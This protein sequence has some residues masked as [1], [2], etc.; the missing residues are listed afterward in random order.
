MRTLYTSHPIFLLFVLASIFISLNAHAAPKSDLW[1]KWLPYNES[2]TTK[3]DHSAWDAFLKKYTIKTGE[4]VRIKYSAVTPADQ[5]SLN[6]YLNQLSQQAVAN[7][8]RQE[9][10]AFWI[11]TYNSLTIKTVLDAYPVS[12]IKKIKLGGVFA[13][14]PWDEKLITIEGAKLSLNDIEHRILR[15]TW[16]DPR[17]HYAVNCA[18]IGCPNL[19]QQ[20]FTASNIDSLLNKGARDYI[21]SA[22][23]V[24]VSGD[25]IKASSIYKWFKEDFGHN[26]AQI[27]VHWMK[28]AR[29]ELK[30]ALEGK[31]HI[32][33]YRY[34]W[35]LN[36]E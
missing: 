21:N 23:G 33:K 32:N 29:P 31:H 25:N 14:G 20:A 36:K 9:Q 10:K 5:Q 19:Q 30:S 17:V 7:L 35:S 2:S 16:K 22:R 11:N 18:S 24:S 15:P 13:S 6:T 26:D 34:D 12:S 3:V 4:L 28:Y 27:I 8:N 1:S